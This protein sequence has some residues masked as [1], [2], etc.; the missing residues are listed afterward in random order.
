M[1]VF[2]VANGLLTHHTGWRRVL[3]AGP[4]AVGGL[5][6]A[7]MP[8]VQA[9]GKWEA[10]LLL[11]VSERWHVFY[12][13]RNAAA[14]AYS[15][16]YCDC[17]C[18]CHCHCHC[19]CTTAGAAAVAAVAAAA[20]AAGGG[21]AIGDSGDAAAISKVPPFHAACSVQVQTKSMRSDRRV[22]RADE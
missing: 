7:C 2:H 1:Q 19:C 17:D 12:Y 15:H 8:L 10:V 22:L 3:I 9:R 6:L 4:Y 20:A 16:Y 13:C 14:A 5:A 21:G 11:M 18:H